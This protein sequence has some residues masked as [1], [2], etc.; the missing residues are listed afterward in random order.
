VSATLSRAQSKQGARPA[1]AVELSTEG[2]LAAALPSHGAAPVYAFAPLMAGTLTPG[3]SEANL[4]KPDKVAVAIGAALGDVATRTRT[5]TLIVPDACVRVFVLD[6]DSLP[7]KASEAVPVIKFRLRK[8]VP[9]DAEHAGVSYQILTETKT[10]CRAL[11]AVMPGPILAEYEAAVRSAG[12]EPG[13]VLPTSLAALAA[14][15]TDEPAM[16]ACL[17]AGALT[18]AITNGEDL[19]LYR[20]LELPVGEAAQRGE[21]QRDIAV[22]AA[23]FEDKLGDRPHRLYFSGP[24]GAEAFAHWLGDGELAVE[25]L[26]ARPATGAAT[27]LGRLSFAGM[28]GALAGAA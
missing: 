16:I 20:T 19:L 11:I 18:T 21:V 4:H 24:M 23:Y 1:A 2:V 14:L 6:F 27:A 7:S 26:A 10:E 9:F 8:M 28:V 13:A 3:S 25:E 12:Y 22:A 15:E 5:V 17:S